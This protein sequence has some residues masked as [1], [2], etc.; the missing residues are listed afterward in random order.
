MSER[1]ACRATHKRDFRSLCRLR[2][3]NLMA[4]AEVAVQFRKGA[5][6]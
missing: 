5:I 2:E 1:V 6:C 4:A 3:R